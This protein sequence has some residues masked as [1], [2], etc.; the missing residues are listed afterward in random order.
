MKIND[1]IYGSFEI[2]EPILI[3]L[4][5]SKP[6]QRL[7]R[8]NQYVAPPKQTYPYPGFSRYEHSVGVMLLLRKMGASL[9]EQVAGLLHDVSHTAFSHLIDWVIGDPAKEDYQDKNHEN[10]IVNSELPQILSDFGFDI[11]A[12]VDVER[13]SL[14]EQEA[15]ALCADRFDY[16]IREFH[17]WSNPSIVKTCVD[18]L[19]VHNGKL[20]FASKEVAEVFGRN[21]LRLQ[22]EH[23][24][25]AK[26]AIRWYILSKILKTALK[27]KIISLSDFYQDDEYVTKK[28]TTCKNTHI[29]Q[30][31]E[32]LSRKLDF[33]LVTH[34][35][36]FN[37]R[38]K[39]RYVDPSYLED[40]ILYRLSA[41]DQ[42][43]KMFLEEHIKR[44]E[45]G[46]RVN[47]MPQ[48]RVE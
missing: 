26:I 17:Y 12:V 35:P 33:E 24:G 16:A 2:E 7:K 19:R 44:N 10:I 32:V 18:H 25:S 23:W 40:G 8:I 6:V 13:H 4:L 34:D 11:D 20:V 21:Y 43:Y 42:K 15:P 38:K 14:L 46:I 5:H 3:A 45:K 48:L 37:L 47:L 29:K 36:Q 39:F 31:F 28:I 41:V 22:N 1:V 27:E 30:L 9:Q